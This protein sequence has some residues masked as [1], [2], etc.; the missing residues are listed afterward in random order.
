MVPDQVSLCSNKHT[1]SQPRSQAFVLYVCEYYCTGPNLSPHIW[2]SF[3]FAHLQWENF[4]DLGAH[5][6]QSDVFTISTMMKNS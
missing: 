4:E 3:D 6:N 2:G 5:F 1:G